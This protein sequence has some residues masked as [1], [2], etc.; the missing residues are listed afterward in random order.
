LGGTYTRRTTFSP[1]DYY[2]L[3][4]PETADMSKYVERYMEDMAPEYDN[5]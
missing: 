3:I 1:E 4:D 2:G 5:E